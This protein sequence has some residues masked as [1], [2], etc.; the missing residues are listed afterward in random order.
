MS[1]EE[2]KKPSQWAK[3]KGLTSNVVL[4]LLR[5][6]GFEVKTAFSPVPIS[7]FA[8]IEKAAEEEKRKQ[9]AR[10]K[11]K[12]PAKADE[13]TPAEQAP[14]EQASTTS[15]TGRKL[16]GTLGKK[17]PTTP[18]VVIAPKKPVAKDATKEIAK[19]EVK[20]QETTSVK[21]EVKNAPIAYLMKSV[22]HI[23]RNDKR[24]PFKSNACTE[25]L[26]AY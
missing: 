24:Q 12:Q 23:K 17:K 26:C 14:A 10:N 1:N 5:D 7:Q 8:T 22:P 4:K 21:Q 6:N 2:H 25:V 20:E 13:Q 19:P 15:A 3:E 9:D 18:K 16:T 11:K